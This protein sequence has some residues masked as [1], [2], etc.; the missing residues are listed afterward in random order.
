MGRGDRIRDVLSG[1]R[2][3]LGAPWFFPIL[4]LLSVPYGIAVRC[5]NLLYNLGFFEPRRPD[6]PVVSVGNIT[7]GGTG[8]TPLGIFLAHEALRRGL[9]PALVSRGYKGEWR[10]GVWVNDEG[11]LLNEVLPGLAVVQDPDRVAAARRAVQDRGA[12]FIILDDA[13]QHRRIGR[14][15]DILTADAR[16]PFG[17]GRLLP[18]GLLREPP[19]GIRRA[20]AVVLTRCEE[21][22]KT[23]LEE[24]RS[25][26]ARLAPGLP[27]FL[28]DHVPEGLSRLG[29]GEELPL[30]KLSGLKVFLCSGIARPESFAATA[31]GLGAVPVGERAF[32]DHHRYG[33]KDVQLVT[34]EARERG[35]DAVL[36]TAKDAVKLRDLDGTREYLVLA[37]GLRFRGG[38]GAFLDLVF[39]PATTARESQEGDRGV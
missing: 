39:S 1:K 38:E 36:T 29:S 28:A 20:D 32:P 3:G 27:V 16:R 37:V 4:L 35:A 30:A 21:T 8:K 24:T 6:V 26:I 31:K 12:D 25:R 33:I 2:R 19:R 34:Q 14:D 18:A 11:L 22:R 10:Q 17:N 7:A 23:D 9:S 13:F 15:R 5:R